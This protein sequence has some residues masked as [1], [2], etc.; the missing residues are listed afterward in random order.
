M[1]G[2]YSQGVWY[3]LV[4]Q[5]HIHTLLQSCRGMDVLAAM[6]RVETTDQDE[7]KVAGMRCQGGC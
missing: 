7:P 1:F 5:P 4:D 6:E 2:R 3:H